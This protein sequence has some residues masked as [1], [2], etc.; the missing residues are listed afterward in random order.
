[1]IKSYKFITNANDIKTKHIQDKLYPEW[2]RVAEVLINK[3]MNHYYKYNS[4]C[5]D[6]SLYKDVYTF[7][8]ERYK[9]AIN[10]QV[11]GL[12]K[13]KVSNFKRKFNKIVL[14]SNLSNEI[15]KDLCLVNKR[16]LFFINEDI[17]G[18]NHKVN[19]ETIKLGRWIFKNFFGK[20]PSCKN[21]N[22]VLQYKIAVIETPTGLNSNIKYVIKL[23]SGKKNIKGKF[24]YIPL[25]NNKYADKF[26]GKLNTSCTLIFKDHKFNSVLITKELDI[27][28][29]ELS[30]VKLSFDIGLNILLATNNGET[31]GK[32]YLK[33]LKKLDDQLM[34]LTNHLKEIHGKYVK[35]SEFSE[36]NKLVNMIRDFSKNEINRIFNK[37]YK[38]YK[39]ETLIMEDLDFKGS[40]IG[41]KNNRLLHRFGLSIIK[42]KLN[43]LKIDYGVKIKFIDAAYSSQTCS[44]CGYIDKNNRKSQKEFECLCC[45]KKINADVNAGKTLYNFEERFGEKL[46]YTV[47][48]RNKKRTL[49][50]NDFIDSKVWT[51]NERLIQALNNNPYK[52]DYYLILREKL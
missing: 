38:K 19:Y 13:S 12:F 9:D 21:I 3:H 41:K 46:F 29:P 32:W 17:H 42:S 20:L 33:K 23:S 7:L 5:I 16:N 22:M 28:K 39:P 34:I 25:L 26:E 2:R 24:Y 14:S 31:Y 15:K 10:R 35:L 43:Q 6:N 18:K 11:V 49:L 8:T 30:K 27:I 36:Y 52:K 51:D 50:I 47:N 37:I 40:N 44:K 45:G 1:M 48:D 4:I